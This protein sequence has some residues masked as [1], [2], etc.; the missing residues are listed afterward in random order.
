MKHLITFLLLAT[1]GY[2]A[3]CQNVKSTGTS[4]SA[5]AQVKQ[6]ISVNDFEKKLVEQPAT[7]LIDVRTADEYN[8]G[9][10]K[11]AVN[12]DVRSEGFEQGLAKLD[13]TKPVLV[14]CLSGGRSSSAADKMQALGFKTVFD[15]DGG[16][17]DWKGADKPIVTGNQ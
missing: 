10:L 17:T 13:K 4:Q 5:S 15:M 1:G 12:I 16:I 14:Y 6:T 7:Q 8:S 3:S 9:H 2:M 11:N